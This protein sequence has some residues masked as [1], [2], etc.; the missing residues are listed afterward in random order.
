MPNKEPSGAF[1]SKVAYYLSEITVMNFMYIPA[2]K[3][4]KIF[5]QPIIAGMVILVFG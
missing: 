4:W 5:D 2:K 1:F 3:A